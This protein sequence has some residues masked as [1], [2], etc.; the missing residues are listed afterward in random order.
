MN[1]SKPEALCRI[2]NLLN[3]ELIPNCHLLALLGAHHILHV[4]GARVNMLVS[5][6]IVLF[7]ICPTPSAGPPFVGGQRLFIEYI[8]C[9]SAYL[10]GT[11]ST[12]KLRTR[13]AMVIGSQSHY[14][15]KLNTE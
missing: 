12:H 2:F 6:G 1:L 15:Q 11:S 4:S 9:N 5:Y 10:E 8:H 14:L 7:A 3:A 13:L